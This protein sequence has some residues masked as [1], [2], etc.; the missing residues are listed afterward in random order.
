MRVIA[1]ENVTGTVVRKLR[2]HGH[3][4]LSVKESRPLPEN[5]TIV[6][7]PSGETRKR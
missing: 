5:G 7:T 2:Q 3:D 1:N 4:V 6:D